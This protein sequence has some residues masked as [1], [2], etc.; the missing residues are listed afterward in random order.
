MALQY[1]KL[2][3][4]QIRLLEILEDDGHTGRLHTV[5]LETAPSYTAL[6]YFWG[7]PP[8]ADEARCF[9]TVNGVTV[10][11]QKNLHN[12]LGQ[13]GATV[14]KYRLMIWIDFLCIDQRNTD[15]RGCQVAMMKKVFEK[16]TVIYAWV[17]LPSNT[18]EVRLAVELMYAFDEML[19]AGLESNDDDLLAVTAG[20]GPD[21]AGYPRKSEPDNARAW[22]G[23]AWIFQQP[24]WH[25]T[26][27]YQEATT[28]GKVCFVVGSETFHHQH[29]GATLYTGRQ[30]AHFPDFTE[31]VG[32][33]S[34]R[35][36]LVWRLHSERIS[37]EQRPSGRALLSLMADIRVTHCA[38]YRDKVYAILG[39]ASDV[40][41]GDFSVDYQRSLTDL[42]IDVVRLS[43]RRQHQLPFAFL[44]H[45][46]IAAPDSADPS[47]NQSYEPAM[48]SWVPDWRQ[49][50]TRSS[51]SAPNDRHWNVLSLPYD[52]SKGTEPS[53]AIRG[54]ELHVRGLCFDRVEEVFPIWDESSSKP[55]TP[56]AWS[57]QVHDS[58]PVITEK[59][60][61]RTLV[62][63][64]RLEDMGYGK[65]R[66]VVRGGL[67]DWKLL[68]ADPSSLDITTRSRQDYMRLELAVC[69]GRRIGVTKG[70]RLG[71]FP[72]AA[73]E[74]DVVAI[75]YGGLVPYAM[76][77]CKQ[78]SVYNF[79]GEC[80]VDGMMDGE[81]LH[82]PDV[83]ETDLVLV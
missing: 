51:L 71:I 81:A 59:A 65:G 15:E 70:G 13:L 49:R 82:L 75:F 41:P 22:H 7:T 28:P 10:E 50:I 4:G 31:Q 63:D 5:D 29:L 25:R 43:Q 83:A 18:E 34:R 53:L 56:Q 76:R 2:Q 64:L 21:S 77:R 66:N 35:M 48:P 26:W 42:Y 40:G 11:T 60:C 72:A 58:Y 3:A 57:Q 1:N 78:G 17:G 44:G 12:A 52:A 20:I 79:L 30:F 19:K 47:L 55:S 23:L 45:V 38:D 24:Y 54:H 68:N 69:F 37:R 33:H 6:S 16:A 67:L 27:I 36:S 14:R 73:A 39:L 61:R 80:Y 32:D 8:A 46:Q 74:G 9:V 62:A